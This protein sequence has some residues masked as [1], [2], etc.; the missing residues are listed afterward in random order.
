MMESL[1]NV[2]F[3]MMKEQ[4]FNGVNHSL[5]EKLLPFS[6]WIQRLSGVNVI[7]FQE[8]NFV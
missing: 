2:E 8:E 6:E 3:W 7:E 4:T 5:Y 1:Q